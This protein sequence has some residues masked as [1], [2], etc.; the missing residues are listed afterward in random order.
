MLYEDQPSVSAVS[1]G[2]E[3][4]MIDRQ[5]YQ[6]HLSEPAKDLLQQKVGKIDGWV[7]L[8]STLVLGHSGVR[9]KYT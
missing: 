8:R 3:C 7:S 6:K 5:F 2:C 9:K 1:G 4:I